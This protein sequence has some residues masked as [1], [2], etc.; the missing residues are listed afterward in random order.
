MI[1]EQN[2]GKLIASGGYGCV[3]SPSLKCEN[4][5]FINNNNISKLMTTKHAQDE[6][7]Q[8]NKYKNI[9]R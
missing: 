6:Y 9:I 2:G 8:I 7:I 1:L 5:D 4:Q 3:F